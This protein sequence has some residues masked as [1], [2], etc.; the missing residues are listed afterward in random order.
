MLRWIEPVRRAIS[1][2]SRI[3]RSMVSASPA[4]MG[5]YVTRSP[6]SVGLAVKAVDMPL[7]SH[8]ESEGKLSDAVPD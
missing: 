5:R 4:R 6:T 7:V 3:R 2:S 1:S 8:R